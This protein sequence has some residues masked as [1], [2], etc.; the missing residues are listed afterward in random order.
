MIFA[1]EEFIDT[2]F[3]HPSESTNIQKERDEK[4]EKLFDEIWKDPTSKDKYPCYFQK[5]LNLLIIVLATTDLGIENI[6]SYIKETLGEGMRLK[7]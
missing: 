1:S 7:R 5:D 2:R 4:A 6:L 3:G